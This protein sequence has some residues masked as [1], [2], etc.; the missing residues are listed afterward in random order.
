[1]P[2]P[3]QRGGEQGVNG[4]ALAGPACPLRDAAQAPLGQRHRSSQGRWSAPRNQSAG[5]GARPGAWRSAPPPPPSSGALHGV[6]SEEEQKGTRP[7]LMWFLDINFKREEGEIRLMKFVIYMSHKRKF[8]KWL[9]L[10]GKTNLRR[11]S[12]TSSEFRHTFV[13]T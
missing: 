11:S 6:F 12:D 2:S 5:P 7:F 9:V 8:S 10:Q 3:A 13:I 4:L 1:M